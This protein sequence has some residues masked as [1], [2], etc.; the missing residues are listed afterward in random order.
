[1]KLHLSTFLSPIDGGE[2]IRI[3]NYADR[4]TMY[5]GKKVDCPYF[6]YDVMGVW[7]ND[8]KIIIEVV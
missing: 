1:M 5:E 7:T 4:R 6:S 2:I 3:V 8:G